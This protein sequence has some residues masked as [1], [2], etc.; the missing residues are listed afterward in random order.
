[1]VCDCESGNLSAMIRMFLPALLVLGTSCTAT[2]ADPARRPAPQSASICDLAAHHRQ[3][4][5]RQVRLK[6]V[7]ISDLSH[8]T[9]LKDESCPQVHVDFLVSPAP[10]Q[11]GNIE[12][13][14]DAVSGDFRDLSLRVYAV[15]LIGVF[16]WLP[17]QQSPARLLV[18]KIIEFHKTEYPSRRS[19][20]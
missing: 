5:G 1:M 6:A 11:D 8:V 16:S 19:A 2:A 9:T 13:F 12:E 20:Q 4:S 7:F 14:Q 18:E 10:M 15:E 17:R 3:W